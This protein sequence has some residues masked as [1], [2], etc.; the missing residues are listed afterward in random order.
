MSIILQYVILCFVMIILSSQN[1]ES[2]TQ[3]DDN[4]YRIDDRIHTISTL[5]DVHFPFGRSQG[6]GFF[7]I[8]SVKK[9][10]KKNFS[11]GQLKDHF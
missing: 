3:Q 5:V 7:I 4:I 2:D 9:I 10:P 6:T 8:N 1:S 11:G